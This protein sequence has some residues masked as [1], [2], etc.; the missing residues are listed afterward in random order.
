[1]G[2]TNDFSNL[3][4]LVFDAETVFDVNGGCVKLPTSVTGGSKAFTV[5]NSNEQIGTIEVE[6]ASGASIENTAM[7]LGGYLRLV[8]IGDG[9]F[10]ATKTAQSYTGGT[11]VAA[12]TMKPGV[13]GTG[14][15]FGITGGQVLVKTGATLDM[16]GK[17]DFYDYT[18]VLDGGELMSS[19]ADLT[20]TTAQLKTVSLTSNSVFNVTTTSGFVGSGY[21]ET[22]LEL[23]GHALDVSISSGKTMILTNA[24][25]D[26]KGNLNLSGAG[27]LEVRNDNSGIGF[28]ATNLDLRA[29][30]EIRAWGAISVHDFVAADTK[31]GVQ[32]GDNSLN[33]YG[34]F[35]PITRYFRGCNMQDGST[36]DFSE[37]PGAWPVASAYTC[38][39]NKTVEFTA[40]TTVKVKIG[41]KKPTDNKI[42]GWSSTPDV[43]F[44]RGDDG[45]IYSLV[46]RDDGLY[47]SF[48]MIIIIR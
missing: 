44:V 29:E 21:A 23:N 47:C 32:L 22:S 14:K 6:V 27:L 48:P 8:K 41:S 11:V 39:G 16:N 38:S 10:T 9:T 12:G 2:V 28:V 37:W 4:S 45:G 17:A 26:G 30:C 3:P 31:D 7:A 42:L 43:T 19:S 5:T 1:M 33:V 13:N 20:V 36:M 40:G 18:I 35:K 34:T 25:S 46:K 15:P 24:R